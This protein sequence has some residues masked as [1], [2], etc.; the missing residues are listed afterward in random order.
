MKLIA[1]VVVLL[2][3]AFPAP[4][5]AEFYRYVDEQGNVH[6]TDNLSDVPAKERP[7]ADKYETLQGPSDIQESERDKQ[8]EEAKEPAARQGDAGGEQPS[9]RERGAE[10]DAEYHLLMK[11]REHLDKAASEPLT[12][13]ARAELA[14]KIKDFNKRMEDYEKRRTPF[15]KEVE[16]YNASLKESTP[17]P[18]A[19]TE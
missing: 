10:L 11:E 4:G 6:Y 19:Q 18:E 16:A 15:N 17:T 12:P 5:S 13:A 9:L 3:T 1:F 7:K 2:V 14:E 8:T